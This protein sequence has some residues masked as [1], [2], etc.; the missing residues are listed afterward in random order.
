MLHFRCC[1][2]CCLFSHFV[3]HPRKKSIFIF[4]L[5][6]LCL[7]KTTGYSA[8]LYTFYTLYNLCWALLCAAKVSINIH[9]HVLIVHRKQTHTARRQKEPHKL[10]SETM[11][12]ESIDGFYR[13][14]QFFFFRFTFHF[15]PCTEFLARRNPF[16]PVRCA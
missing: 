10:Y 7:Q 13:E 2:C 6:A 4:R 14:I 9:K 8:R 12:I 5:N 1:C 3:F 15:W 11:K 16:G